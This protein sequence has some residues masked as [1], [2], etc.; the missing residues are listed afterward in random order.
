MPS[1]SCTAVALPL[2]P[3]SAAVSV[4]HQQR[5]SAGAK[6]SFGQAFPVPLGM[7]IISR[8]SGLAKMDLHH[9]H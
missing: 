3:P 9:R 8:L 1:P 4:W 5:V 7:L 6:F 2:L